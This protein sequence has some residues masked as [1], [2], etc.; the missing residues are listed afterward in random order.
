MDLSYALIPNSEGQPVILNREP[1]Y[2]EHV[3]E[4]EQVEYM[5]NVC[6]LEECELEEHMMENEMPPLE[7]VTKAEEDS[8]FD[9]SDE[10]IPW[11]DKGKE[12]KYDQVVTIYEEGT[13]S[14]THDPMDDVYDLMFAQGNM[15][16]VGD[17]LVP[18]NQDFQ[19][20]SQYHALDKIGNPSDK[21][22]NLSG[23]IKEVID[24]EIM[25]VHRN[26]GFKEGDLVMVW[27]QAYNY[28]SA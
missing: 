14:N 7:D 24:K 1:Y 25:M 10:M 26:Q 19:V 15:I 12:K 22:P 18:L 17:I 2:S 6:F 16:L 23:V 13:S 20:T 9:T 21:P 3:E 28:D 27:N 11:E 8:F 4:L 5:D